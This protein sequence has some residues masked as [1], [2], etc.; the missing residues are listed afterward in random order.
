MDA[1][2]RPAPPASE[3]HAGFLLPVYS[4][5]RRELVRFLRQPHRVF[6]SIGQPVI[7]WA[8]FGAGLR[9][10]FHAP[11]FGGGEGFA[12]YFL[13]GTVAMTLLFTAIFS[14]ISIIEDRKEGFLQSVLVAP[15]PRAAMVF[16][17]V[18]GGALL[19]L[20]HALPFALM[21]PMV[22]A[23]LNP[24]SFLAL[25]VFA[26]LCGLGLSALGFALAWRLDSSQGFHGAMTVLLFPMLLLSGAFFPVTGVPSALRTVMEWNPMTYAVAGLRRILYP[27]LWDPDLPGLKH[28]LMVTIGTAVVF[29]ALAWAVSAKRTRADLQ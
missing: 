7:F 12:A 19:A 16:G 1:V 4:L 23:S 10:S 24:L 13:P 22:G 25:G 20:L 11:G 21:A 28:S 29:F 14:S 17:K 15:I 27:D 9:G 18:L 26:F 2:S 6:G 5:T 3:P 8:L